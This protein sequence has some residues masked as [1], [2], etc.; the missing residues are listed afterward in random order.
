MQIMDT[1]P[2]KVLFQPSDLNPQ[3][4]LKVYAGILLHWA[5]FWIL[6]AVVGGLAAYGVSAMSTPI[7]QASS[8]LLINQA[9]STSTAQYQDIL[10]SERIARTYAEL[11]PRDTTQQ[12]VIAQLG[13]S[14]EQ[15][16]DVITAISV[17]PVRD[18]QLVRVV[19]E[20]TEPELVAQ[21]ANLLPAVFI[22]EIDQQQSERYAES[23]ANLQEQ[24][25]T[26]DAQ[27]E[28]TQSALEKLDTAV[29][30]HQEVE[31]G[32]LRNTLSQYQSSYANVLQ[33]F[34][35]L[36]LTEVQSVDSIVMAEPAQLPI[37]P[38]RPRTLINTLLAAIAS[39]LTALG[40]IFLFEYMDDGVKSPF[41]LQNL[42][43]APL[44]GTI[45]R[46]RV[47]GTNDVAPADSLI[48][49]TAPRHPISEAFRGVRTN[50]QFS[51]VDHELRAMMVTSPNP[52]DG[53]TT[54]AAN[55][56][57]VVA[58]SGKSVILVDAD[59][60][61]PRIHRLL[62]LSQSPG[63]TDLLFSDDPFSIN[64][65]AE[66]F[67]NTTMSHLNLR[68]LPSGKQPPNPSELLGSERMKRLIQQLQQEADLV[69]FDA[70]PLRA[71]TDAQVLGSQLDGVLLV[72]DSGANRSAVVQAAEALQQV[73]ARL[74]GT[75]LNR[76]TRSS[77]SYNYYYDYAYQY[78]YTSDGSDNSDAG[79]GD[80]SQGTDGSGPGSADRE[81]HTRRRVPRLVGGAQPASLAVERGYSQL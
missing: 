62:D 5:W 10:S 59:L 35:T 36:R 77:R 18:T 76:L 30:A 45:A 48:T 25:D 47:N 9:R 16:D 51:S 39:A 55:L 66:P 38:V 60:R 73:N 57:A 72:V 11:M 63:L 52:G 69:I 42:L 22:R 80:S 56:A 81:S 33:S 3:S 53:K 8:T 34:E 14:V 1:V 12:Q 43:D 61:K 28:Q 7:Y 68:V 65:L 17:S 37:V 19:V 54:T 26:L 71:V 13:L 4:D 46:I 21:V 70:P 15:F 40:I 44:L 23:K 75:V 58:Q 79:D 31:L 29:T 24:L 2:N 32:R 67:R 78:Y 6:M 74:L 64:Q 27:I 49:M 41:E 20:G 50:L